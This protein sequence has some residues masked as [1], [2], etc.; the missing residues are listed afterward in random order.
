MVKSE[1]DLA[2]AVSAIQDLVPHERMVLVLRDIE[3]DLVGANNKKAR[4]IA[5]GHSSSMALLAGVLELKRIASPE[6]DYIHRPAG[7][8]IR[9]H[10]AI[11]ALRQILGPDEVILA[12]SL[13]GGSNRR[14]ATVMTNQRA[15]ELSLSPWRQP[16]DDGSQF[17]HFLADVFALA[18]DPTH[19]QRREIY[20]Q[21]LT[22]PRRALETAECTVGEALAGTSLP[23]QA[24]F[25]QAF[26][27]A[28]SSLVPDYWATVKS[29]VALRD[30]G[31]VAPRLRRALSRLPADSGRE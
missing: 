3:T 29:R 21:N 26:A 5:L 24:R 9:A 22:H 31:E 20:V 11:L 15:F 1:V 8:Y 2:G 30:I 10:G 28:A 19:L 27:Q 14:C 17:P 18:E 16:A 12:A 23:S 4:E 25:S 6:D 7:A 13:D